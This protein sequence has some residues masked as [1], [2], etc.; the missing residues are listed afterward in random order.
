MDHSQNSGIYTRYQPDIS[1]VF[2]VI[3]LS[4]DNQHGLF[5]VANHINAISQNLFDNYI[6]IEAYL[7][8]EFSRRFG[9][10]E[11]DAFINGT[12]IDVPTGILHAAGGGEV[13]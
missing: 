6:K 1:P 4:I 8:I 11:E 5:F 10:A 2:L 9:R 12:G 3:F 7:E 13:G